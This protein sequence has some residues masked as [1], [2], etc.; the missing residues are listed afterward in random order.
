MAAAAHPAPFKPESTG[1]AAHT[2]STDVPAP[3]SVL[4]PQSAAAPVAGRT[5]EADCDR[6]SDLHLWELGTGHLGAIL[7]VVTRMPRDASF[8]RDRLARFPALSHVTVGV[9]RTRA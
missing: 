1:N 3:V 7:S 5:D 6:L 8:Y 2:A 9:A 4:N